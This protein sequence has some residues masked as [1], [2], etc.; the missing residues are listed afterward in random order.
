M[1]SQRVP[2]ENKVN[3]AP[4]YVTG[5][6]A[7]ESQDIYRLFSLIFEQRG[8]VRSPPTPC[9]DTVLFNFFQVSDSFENSLGF[10]S[11]RR[12]FRCVPEAVYMSSG[13]LG[14]PAEQA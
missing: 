13:L 11:G 2:W 4:C 3:K 9:S 14:L 1:Q 12:A 8:H 7:V 10:S 6:L 5:L